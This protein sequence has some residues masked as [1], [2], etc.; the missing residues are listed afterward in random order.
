ME[1]IFELSNPELKEIANNLQ[2]KI[3]EGLER[4]NAEILAIPTYLNPPKGKIEDQK[5]LVLD[6]GGTNFRAAIVEFK[7][8]LPIIIDSVKGTLSSQDTVGFDMNKLMEKMTEYIEQLKL[9]DSIVRIGY[10]FSYPA[11]S[12]RNGDAK[13]LRWTKG[14]NIPDMIGKT[15]G[16]HLLDYLN[17]HKNIP[18]RFRSIK[19]INDTVSCLF[20]GLSA[21]GRD[22]Y[23]G[24][25]VGTGTNMAALMPINK[26]QKVRSKDTGAIPVNLESGNFK[27]PYLTTI[28]NLVDAMSNSQGNQRF[29]KAISGGYLGEIFKTIFPLRRIPYNFDAEGLSNMITHPNDHPKEFVEAAN[30]IYTRS[31]YLVAASIAGLVQV[32]K[33][34]NEQIKNVYL[35][36]DGSLFWSNHYLELVKNKFNELLSTVELEIGEQREHPN[37][38]GSAIAAL[39]PCTA[40]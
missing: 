20:A 24:L 18:C 15:I 4:E 23:I 38:I 16:E 5:V 21:Q 33:K 26:I 31:A 40:W 32:L 13:L 37:L 39:A 6:W 30:W 11:S 14:F 28:D 19:V 35:A 34:Q 7:D 27:P 1:N 8:N 17:N 29:E 10:C 9:D 22:A 3:E 36:A 2:A 12:E 25:I